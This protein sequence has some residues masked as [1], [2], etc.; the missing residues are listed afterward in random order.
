MYTLI[1]YMLNIFINIHTCNSRAYSSQVRD[2]SSLPE[3]TG[4]EE[5][6]FLAQKSLPSTLR[7]Y[8]NIF[9]QSYSIRL[10][11][12]PCQ[13]L[14]RINLSIHNE[15]SL[16]CNNFHGFYIFYVAPSRWATQSIVSCI[17]LMIYVLI[18]SSQV[19]N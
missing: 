10:F 14:F 13:F 2:Y 11:L 4:T 3:E 6:L 19:A 12:S 5:T 15:R 16:I 17:C 18:R 9:T 8:C 7:L 1:L